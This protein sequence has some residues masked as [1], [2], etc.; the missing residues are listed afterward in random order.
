MKSYMDAINLF[1]IIFITIIIFCETNIVMNL[2]NIMFGGIYKAMTAT[3][4]DH[5]VTKPT[6]KMMSPSSLHRHGR[7][8]NQHPCHRLRR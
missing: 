6:G 4:S 1:I 8:L 5:I 7:S 3:S 2:N